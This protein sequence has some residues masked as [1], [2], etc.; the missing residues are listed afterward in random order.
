MHICRE[1]LSE[2]F[3]CNIC[4]VRYAEVGSHESEHPCNLCEKS[5]QC[6]TQLEDHYLIHEEHHSKFCRICQRE[7]DEHATKRKDGY[8]YK[9][10]HNC[11]H[12]FDNKTSFQC[13][14]YTHSKFK[15]FKCDYC[16]ERFTLKGNLRS[17]SK[18]HPKCKICR[19][20]FVDR[21]S[22][23]AHCLEEHR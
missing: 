21:N 6:I 10:C 13:H 8:F 22:L 12:E 20:T 16:G 15:L 23:D 3:F 11:P 17:H 9:C 18:T 5:F 2:P 1:H 14:L 19:K 4:K 7:L